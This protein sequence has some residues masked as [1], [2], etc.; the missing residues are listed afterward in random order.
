MAG[1][2]YDEFYPPNV[3]E[4]SS[5]EKLSRDFNEL[6]SGSVLI[7]FS[8]LF[9]LTLLLDLLLVVTNRVTR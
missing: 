4:P 1:G 6:D 8:V 7:I 5:S 9:F 2:L 3:D